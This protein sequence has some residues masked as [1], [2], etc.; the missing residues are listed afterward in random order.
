[1]SKRFATI[2]FVSITVILLLVVVFFIVLFLA[3]GVSIFGLKYIGQGLHEYSRDENLNTI[4]GGATFNGITVN[5]YEAPVYVVFTEDWNYEVVY[6]ENFNGLTTS[7][8]DNPSLDISSTSTNIVITTSEYHRAVYETSSSERYLKLY[9]P[10]AAIKQG[11]TGEYYL[12]LT[13]NSTRSAVYFSKAD[14]T[15]ESVA[16][17]NNISVTTKGKISYGTNMLA[18]TY[19]LTT[20]STI[21]LNENYSG[22]IQATNYNLK[23]TSGKIAIYQA[24]SGD[25]TAQTKNGSISLVS[26]KNLY[27]TTTYGAIKSSGKEGLNV[28]GIV[29]ITTKAGNVTLG[30]VGGIGQNTITTSSGKVKITSIGDGIITTKRGSVTVS[31]LD[32][33]EITTDVGKVV[34]EEA[35]EALSVT[36]KRGDIVLGTKSTKVND[37]TVFSRLGR[38]TV[39]SATGNVD[40][41]TVSSNVT[42]TNSSS[43]NININAGGKL[44]AYKLTGTVNVY[45]NGNSY[46][47]FSTITASS[48]FKFGSSCKTLKI[49]AL[50]NTKENTGLK[51]NGANIIIMEQKNNSYIN[52]DGNSSS[53]TSYEKNTTLSN[54]LIVSAEKAAITLYLTA[55][56]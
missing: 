27:A 3:P 14:S 44:S 45:A 22:F 5:T 7:K 30:N 10:L 48:E 29:K 42:F 25:L 4:A 17:F 2:F 28:S 46:V 32:N 50:N 38:V 54:C 13:I 47:E 33:F 18:T 56:A 55:S 49:Y 20:S 1:M 16:T 9:I 37:I 40:I 11:G 43:S 35:E 15:D 12:N 26:C 51:L 8:I 6:Y 34:V 41:E 23:S 39:I 53:R 52:V 31:Q 36:T 21:K 19:S 24:I